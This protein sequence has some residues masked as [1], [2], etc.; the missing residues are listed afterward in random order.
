MTSNIHI[1]FLCVRRQQKEYINEQGAVAASHMDGGVGLQD[2][3]RV[4]V[5]PHRPD[6]PI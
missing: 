5:P 3:A 4:N 2:I 6:N 1:I